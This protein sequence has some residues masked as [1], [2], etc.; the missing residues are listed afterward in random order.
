MFQPNRARNPEETLLGE[1]MIL[2]G[3]GLPSID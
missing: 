1:S 2:A 3:R